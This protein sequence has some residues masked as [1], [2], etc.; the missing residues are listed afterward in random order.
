M[1]IDDESAFR[2]YPCRPGRTPGSRPDLHGGDS[3]VQ[4]I[5]GMAAQCVL[6]QTENL[7][8]RNL[9]P[10]EDNGLGLAP[11]PQVQCESQRIS[12]IQ[13][14]IHRE[15]RSCDSKSQPRQWCGY[16]ERR[17]VACELLMRSTTFVPSTMT[18]TEGLPRHLSFR[19]LRRSNSSWPFKSLNPLERSGLEKIVTAC[20]PPS[21]RW[22][23]EHFWSCERWIFRYCVDDSWQ[24]S[25]REIL[26]DNCLLI[27]LFKGYRKYKNP[28]FKHGVEKTIQWALDDL[29]CP[30]EGFGS[31][32]SSEVQQAEGAQ[33]LWSKEELAEILT[34]ADDQSLLSR[35]EPIEGSDKNTFLPH[36]IESSTVPIGQQI[37]ILSKLR[38][39]ADSKPREIDPK[40]IVGANALWF[41]P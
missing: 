32:V 5:S 12:K 31:S 17:I 40:R 8:G 3:Y 28:L 16:F 13:R 6:L 20:K 1:C 7:F 2:V 29:G 39:L 18:K 19:P 34:A 41:V 10:K 9:L 35:W 33:Y 4:P 24:I 15:C 27:I 21:W 36:L 38:T 26:A 23:R 11:W 25:F 22:L 37:K 14:W 30:K